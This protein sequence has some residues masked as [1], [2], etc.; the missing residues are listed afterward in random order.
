VKGVGIRN[1][2]NITFGSISNLGFSSGGQIANYG[3]I[4]LVSSNTNGYIGS[5]DGTSAFINYNLLGVSLGS[6]QIVRIIGMVNNGTIAIRSGKKIPYSQFFLTPQ[7]GSAQFEGNWK[8]FKNITRMASTKMILAGGFSSHYFVSGSFVT[9]ET[10]APPLEIVAGTTTVSGTI[11]SDL[12]VSAGETYI[13][14]G[15]LVATMVTC[16]GSS[17]MYLG[18]TLTLGSL[19]LAVSGL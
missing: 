3:I 5:S 10:T 12:I 16:N 13:N 15:T 6:S 14:G 18:E 2:G 8:N 1:D 19:T 11:V 9:L 17:G 7:K 4:S